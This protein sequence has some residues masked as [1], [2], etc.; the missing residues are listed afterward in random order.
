M[1]DE[2][3]TELLVEDR[4]EVRVLAIDRTAR[5]NALTVELMDRLTDEIRAADKEPATRAIVLTGVGDHF[6]AGGDADSIL[7][8][9][10]DRPP[11]DAVTFMKHYHAAV[12]AIWDS[13]LPIVAG[14]RGVAYGGGFNLALACDLIVADTTARFCQV[15]VRRDVVPDMGGAYLLPRA[16]GSHRAAD[17]MLRGGVLDAQQALDQGLVCAL[18]E[19]DV[20]DTAVAVAREATT[21]SRA[22]VAMTKRL[23]HAAT[24]T[25]L[26]GFLHT[27]ALSQALALRSEGARQGFA[28]F[29]SD[30]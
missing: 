3:T 6:S 1:T 26:H 22:T 18:V 24:D 12:E 28:A 23:L 15:F 21:A 2:K 10:A 9:V 14:V 13:E 19:G 4:A 29:R 30:R 16:V 11:Y 27:E 20:T 17:L 7:D 5:R 25:T 8:T